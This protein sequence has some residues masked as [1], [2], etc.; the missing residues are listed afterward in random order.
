MSGI[1]SGKV[2]CIGET[3]LDIIFQGRVPVAATPGGSM[4]NSAVSLGR[5][6]LPVFLVSDFANDR[7]G[8]LIRDFLTENKVS[9]VFIDRYDDGKTSVA[10]AFLDEHRHAEYSFYRILPPS[11]LNTTMPDAGSGD[12]ILFGSFYSLTSGVRSKLIPF[13][14]KAKEKGALI[15]Y[16][17]NF[18]RP[19][20]D[21]LEEKRPLILENISLASLVRGSDEDFELIFS[22][23]DGEEAYRHVREAGCSALIYTKNARGVELFT[24]ERTTAYEV[25]SISP[26]STIGAGDAFNAG[27]IYSIMHQYSGRDKILNFSS[28]D[29][30]SI[31]RTGIRFA[32]E[33]CL[34][35]ENYVPKREEMN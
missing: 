16:D 29:W 11:R 20:L 9:T 1:D 14:R 4:L 26:V 10:L 34:S 25:P 23:M 13:I 8:D 24:E 15:L 28:R 27:I 5:M 3:V 30:E 12:I 2:F 35:M 6:G 21:E 31:I 22:A 18:R 32:E 7:A 33:V 17:P 19:H